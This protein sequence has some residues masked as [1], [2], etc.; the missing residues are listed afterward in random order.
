MNLSLFPEDDMS[1]KEGPRNDTR[2]WARGHTKGSMA[3]RTG[4][5][6]LRRQM[7]IE[8]FG[9]QRE[10]K[11]QAVA[12]R[13]TILFPLGTA[14]N[15]PKPNLSWCGLDITVRRQGPSF[16]TLT[17]A[18]R[19][20]APKDSGGGGGRRRSTADSAIVLLHG[21]KR[22]SLSSAQREVPPDQPRL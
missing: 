15:S 13:M 3:R 5:D 4:N 16:S 2:G 21:S 19:R 17:S 20:R 14:Q 22:R 11:S 9:K 6:D 12:R 8:W 10:E 7:S 18:T 1:D